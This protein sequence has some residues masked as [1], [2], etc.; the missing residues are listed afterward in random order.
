MSAGAS[1]LSSPSPA[2]VLL[3][4]A[5]QVGRSPITPSS[6]C[7][8]MV[9]PTHPTGWPRT[10]AHTALGWET[11]PHRRRP[12]SLATKSD[13]IEIP[14]GWHLTDCS[15]L[16]VGPPWNLAPSPAHAEQIWK[17][18]FDYREQK[19]SREHGNPI[20]P[21]TGR[22][23][24]QPAA[25]TRSVN[26]VH[27]GVRTERDDSGT[28]DADG[29]L[30]LRGRIKELINR[31]GEKISPHKVGA[32][33]LNHTAVAQAVVFGAPTQKTAR[34]WRQ[35][36]SCGTPPATARSRCQGSLE[37]PSPAHANS[38]PLVRGW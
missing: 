28:L 5:H 2:S 22:S 27:E 33:L 15:Q 7:S 6:S 29:Y 1:K 34:Q 25:G 24:R 10:S 26:R 32:V 38:P 3:D 31:G 35:R 9:L 17:D 21:V 36:S 4:I 13:L 23:A 18:E 20:R 30:H 8:S 37:F 12:S 19:T 14:S 16:E 11:K